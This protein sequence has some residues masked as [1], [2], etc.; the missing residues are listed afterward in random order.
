LITLRQGIFFVAAL[1][2]GSVAAWQIIATSIADRYARAAPERA[3]EWDAHN[4][5]A[6]FTIARRQLTER[7]AK[8]AVVTARELLRVEPLAGQAFAVLAEAAEAAGE[9]DKARALYEVA[10]RRAPQNLRVRAWIIDAQLREG[11]YAEALAQIDILLTVSP[12]QYDKLLPILA[13]LAD[14]PEFASAL[15]HTLSGKPP[16]RVRMLQILPADGSRAAIDQVYGLL[17][18]DGGL[19]TEEAGRW[20][21][22]LMQD[23]LWGEA[24]SRWAGEL[25]LAP[26]TSLPLV[27]NGGFQTEPSGIGFDWRISGAT[28]V[29][30]DRIAATGANG[31]FAMQVSF[32]GRRV[33]QI[34]FEQR[35]LLAPDVYQLSFR[36]RAEALNSDK[37]LQWA[38]ACQGQSEPLAVSAP[39][40][41]SFDWKTFTVS[42]VIPAENCPAQHLWLRNPGA[43]AAGKEV[44]GD[45]WFDDI[46]IVKTEMPDPEAR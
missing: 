26:G 33:P 32:S 34:N 14:A 10:L 9:T 28:G 21:D 22:Q 30:I 15:A 39:L 6:L 12:E 5:A 31:A 35:L 40:G 38:I 41:G 3:L 11:R 43:A 37:G 27:Y 36:A 24:Y 29:I 7:D 44:V 45:I 46:T 17:Q 20:Y 19:S 4:P 2:L 18:H 42:F 1:V 13:R 23:G 25:G 16:W 8:A